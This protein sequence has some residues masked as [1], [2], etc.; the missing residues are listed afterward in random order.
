MTLFL[1]GA[2]AL[3][4]ILSNAQQSHILR[5]NNNPVLATT[6]QT[7]YTDLAVAIAAAQDGDTIHVEGSSN[8]YATADIQIAAQN[9]TIIGPGYKLSGTGAN[10]GLQAN[11][12]PATIARKLKFIAGSQG[13]KIM[14]LRFNGGNS[15]VEVSQTDHITIERNFFDG[16]LINFP[17]VGVGVSDIIIAENII[18]G[19]VQN[20]A[21]TINNL[22]IRNNLVVGTIDLNDPNDVMDNLSVVNNTFIGNN[23]TQAVRNAQVAYNVF[24]SGTITGSSNTIHDNLITQALTGFPDNLVVQMGTQ[25]GI[26]I[27]PASDDGKWDIPANATYAP[28]GADEYGMFSGIS[29]YRLSGIPNIPAI[30]ALQSTLNASPGGTVQVTLSTRTN[31]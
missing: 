26:P 1:A 23:A 18:Q 9:L 21:Q 14:G 22:A 17:S 28:G 24:Y 12:W 30:Y 2:M 10:T 15:G 19:I 8:S 7:C 3:V 4:P 13:A 29:P 6:C 27:T 31:P 11:T 5:V 20:N 16:P 25:V